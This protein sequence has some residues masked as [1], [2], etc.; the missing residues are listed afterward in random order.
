MKYVRDLDR[1]IIGLVANLPQSVR[2][3][4][5]AATYVGSPAAAALI[6]IVVMGLTYRHKNMRLL[7]AEAAVFGLLPLAPIVKL[8]TQRHRPDTLYAANMRFKSYS[9]PSGHAY[10]SLLVFGFLAFLCLHYVADPWRWLLFGLL[11]FVIFLVGISRIYLG[12]H[13]PSDV[14]GGWLLGGIVLFLILRFLVKF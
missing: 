13:F 4:M 2:P 5:L 7:A 8:F 10:A 14:L 6:L 11:F 12:A 3:V 1:N 9:F